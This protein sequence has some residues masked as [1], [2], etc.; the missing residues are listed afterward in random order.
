MSELT[1][2]RVVVKQAAHA[3]FLVFRIGHERYALQAIEVAEVLPRLPLKPIA[4]APHWVAGVLA[5]RGAVVPVIDLSALA[6]GT[7]AQARTSTRL[8]LVHYRPDPTA[9]AQ[10]L[11]LILERATD[12]LRCDPTDFQPY[13]LDNPQAR[14]LGPVREDAQGLLQWVRV[15]ELLDDQV[16]A[17]LYPTQP[18]Y[19]TGL[20]AQR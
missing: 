9:E 4:Q 17:L 12:T 3:L 18:L 8:V 15:A 14:Y 2:K 20:E 19:L 7:P 5:Y 10:L 1:A 6:F 13:G 11:G 16:R